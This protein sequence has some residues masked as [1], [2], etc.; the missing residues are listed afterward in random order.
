MTLFPRYA[1]PP[2]LPQI[3]HVENLTLAWRRVRRNIQL[4]QRQRS[5]GVDAM[6]IRDFEADWPRQM[7]QLADQLLDGSYRPLPAR[8]AQ[9]PK[10]TGGQRAIAI[11]A[12][13]DRVA[14]RAV[15]QVLDPLFDP[16]LLD[17]AY[18]SRPHVGVPD[19]L[20]RV[21]RYAAQGLTWVAESD[22][23]AFFDSI[24]QRV[25]LSLVRQRVAEPQLLRLLGQWLA[26]GSV[27]Q[28]P[29]THAPQTPLS[30]AAAAARAL[31]DPPPAPPVATYPP[32]DDLGWDAPGWDAPYAGRSANLANHLWTVAQ[33]APPVLAQAKRLLPHLQHVGAG[34]LALAGGA[35]AATFAAIDAGTRY[36]ARG[37]PQG[38]ALSPL[39]ANIYLH[40]FDLALTSAGFRLVRY[41]DDFVVLCADEREAHDALTLARRQLQVLRLALK[42]EKTRIAAY[43]DG[44]AF[45]GTTLRSP[46]RGVRLEDG[47][48]SFDE[49]QQR[50]RQALR[51]ERGGR[52]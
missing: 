34:K 10:A 40:P 29:A 46:Q 1:G 9:I 11:L 8:T 49:A 13:R 31:L 41:V 35:V 39:L 33:Y 37:T 22:I 44:I 25:L 7:A 12:V 24:D 16:H 17:C 18:G 45:L 15:Q 36:L 51:R 4:A 48:T 38:S 52:S 20:A 6:T 26:V 19:A 2:L 47:L 23:A 27:Q 42:E 14:Q 50:L 3:C 28:E 32:L 30:R 21:E 43:D 5:A